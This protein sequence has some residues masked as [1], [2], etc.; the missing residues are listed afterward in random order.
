MELSYHMMQLEDESSVYA[1][2][3]VTDIDERKRRELDLEDKAGHDALTGLLNRQSGPP[4][5]AAALERTVQHDCE[6]AFVIIDLDDFKLVN[7]TYGHLPGDTVLA[8]AAQ[9]LCASFGERDLICRWGGDEFVVYCERTKRN[10]I[11]KSM[12]SLCESAWNAILPSGQSIEL[13]V[14][15]GIAMVP[16]DGSTFEAVY[17]RA[18]RALYQA[19]SKGKA[20]YC[21]FEATMQA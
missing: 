19:K 5:I 3:S 4:C 20:H 2:L 11:E 8:D 7:D 10:D 12:A 15:I 14:S 13:S 18:D 9:H 6:G 21:F 16:Q 17:E 1:Y